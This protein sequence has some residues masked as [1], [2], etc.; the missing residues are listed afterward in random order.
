MK[1]EISLIPE[2]C[3]LVCYTVIKKKTGVLLHTL[4]VSQVVSYYTPPHSMR[5]LTKITEITV[6]YDTAPLCNHCYFCYYK[7]S[8]GMRRSVI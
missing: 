5:V 7:K 6:L 4:G 8:H 1:E 3:P 2:N